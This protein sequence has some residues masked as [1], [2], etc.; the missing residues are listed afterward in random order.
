VPS[1]D[2]GMEAS[3]AAL[4]SSLAAATDELSRVMDVP[5][6]EEESDPSVSSV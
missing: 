1:I 4:G 6:P 2:F 3:L 5:P